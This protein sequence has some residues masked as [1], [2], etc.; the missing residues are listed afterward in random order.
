MN[1]KGPYSTLPSN[2][3][4]LSLFKPAAKSRRGNGKAIQ[5]KHIRWYRRPGTNYNRR[6][7][8]C[9]FLKVAR[10]VAQ[11]CK[12]GNRE[13]KLYF[14]LLKSVKLQKGPLGQIVS[15]FQYFTK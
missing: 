7:N 14:L 4:N 1:N 15:G 12:E 6:Q 8:C 5:I 9:C 2:N 10:T 3:F 11:H 13:G